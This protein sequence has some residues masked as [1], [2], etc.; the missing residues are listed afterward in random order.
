[1]AASHRFSAVARAAGLWR[2]AALACGMSDGA[3]GFAGGFGIL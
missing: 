1:L 2:V 3:F